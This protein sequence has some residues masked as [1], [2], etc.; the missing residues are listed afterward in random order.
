MDQYV[1]DSGTIGEG[2]FG[3]VQRAVS[4]ATGNPVALKRI[5][6]A[7][8]Q[9]GLPTSVAREL[10]SLRTL[11][12][13]PNI[14]TLHDTFP[15][16]MGVVIVTELCTT[17]LVS[18]L[19]RYSA[20]NRLPL[21]D[22]KRYLYMLLAALEHCYKHRI[23]H[24][25]IKP[26]N[27]FI[28]AGGRL[29]LG[30]FGLAR[31]IPDPA[32]QAMMTHEVATRWYRAPELL[33][34]A[35][36]YY[37]G[38]I[39]LWGVGCVFAELLSGTTQ[40]VLFPGEGDIDQ[41]SK[42]FHVLGTPNEESWPEVKQLPDWSKITINA[43]EGVGLRAVVRETASPE[44]LDLLQGL[45]CLNPNLRLTASQALQHPFFRTPPFASLNPT[46]L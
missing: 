6:I 1:V 29:K 45:L 37:D 4:K 14:L 22:A 36:R 32:S 28:T 35:R 16:G 7:R 26:A 9:E 24:R 19:G 30:D 44:A 17:D 12:G 23:L 11:Q 41:M 18:L 25:D 34:G 13:H 15:R 8:L 40:S 39:D 5:P 43:C 42:I 33:L 46:I 31:M 21:A 38:A 20:T 2:C 27:C 3:S 10:I